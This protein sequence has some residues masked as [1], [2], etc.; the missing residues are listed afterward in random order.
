MK[1][2]G[3]REFERSLTGTLRFLRRS[4]KARTCAFFLLNDDGHLE[5]RAADGAPL[6]AYARLRLDA[7]KSPWT[8]CLA[9]N[10]IFE[11]ALS[12]S[13]TDMSRI[14]G[15]KGHSRARMVVV[16]VMGERRRLGILLV[17]PVPAGVV[18]KPRERELRMAGTL[19]A[20]ISANWRL[21]QWLGS[22]LSQMN[23]DLRTPLT[24]V[25]GSLGMLLGGV[26]GNVEGEVQAMLQMAQ[27]GCERT[28]VA[29][30]EHLQQ[31]AISS[32]QSANRKRF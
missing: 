9:G 32:Q 15:F 21:H 26:F 19:C 8:E 3:G 23:D 2:R 27:K 1:R 11:R 7:R 10:R 12:D 22:F 31:S 13:A 17:G 18:L 24:A 14:P 5:V 6:N 4:M 28:V 20:V 16:P 30:E 25:K 29:I